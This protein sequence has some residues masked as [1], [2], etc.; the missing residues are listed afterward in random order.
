MKIFLLCCVCLATEAL[1][2]SADE[3]TPATAQPAATALP[4]T[5]QPPTEQPANVQTEVTK[6]EPQKAELKSAEAKPAEQANKN[7]GIS[8]AL[9]GDLYLA[10]ENWSRVGTSGDSKMGVG[11]GGMI[12]AG[13]RI[14]EMKVIVGPHASYNRWSAD[15]SQK[16]QSA[17][18]SVYVTM[19]D[20]GVEFKAHFDD[21]FIQL[22]TG[23]SKIGSGMIVSG[24]DIQYPYSGEGY[25]YKS[26]GIGGKF[27]AIMLAVNATSYSGYAQY[28]NRIEFILGLAF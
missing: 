19:S 21:L 23:S 9:G 28:A 11:F 22:G 4:S 15:Y 14:D 20:T 18:D 10:L 1:V 6:P 16:A 8:F 17:T 27:D 12:G 24:K 26:V 13:L 3:A 5:P 25:T 7:S 2:A